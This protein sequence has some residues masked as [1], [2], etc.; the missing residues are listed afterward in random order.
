MMREPDYVYHG[1]SMAHIRTELRWGTAAPPPRT[2]PVPEE[3]EVKPWVLTRVDK[4]APTARRK[5]VREIWEVLGIL[6]GYAAI[7][8]LLALVLAMWG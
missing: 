4:P 2:Q 3:V 6:L 8:G 5:Q 7:Y 1:A